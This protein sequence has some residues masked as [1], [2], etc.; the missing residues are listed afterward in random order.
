MFTGE[1]LNSSKTDKQAL[2]DSLVEI[3]RL[4]ENIKSNMNV[5]IGL[6]IIVLGLLFRTI[7][8]SSY[9]SSFG[10]FIQGL[11]A[12]LSIGTMLVGVVWLVYGLAKAPNEK[13]KKN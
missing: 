6:F 3:V 5:L 1:R 4:Y 13:S 10:Q 7:Q 12:G 11:S 9:S 8:F 2:E